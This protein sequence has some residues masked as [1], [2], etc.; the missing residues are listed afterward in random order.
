MEA[1]PAS[2]PNPPTAVIKVGVGP[3]NLPSA[4]WRRLHWPRADASHSQAPNDAE[5]SQ[6]LKQAFIY[7]QIRK[8]ASEG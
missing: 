1:S 6:W 3:M 8:A 2:Q 5:T 7:R 4:A